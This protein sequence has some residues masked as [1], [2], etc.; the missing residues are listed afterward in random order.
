VAVPADLALGRADERRLMQVLLN[1]VGNAIKF[2][3]VGKVAIRAELI[4]DAFRVAVTDT[5]PGIAEGDRERIFEEFQQADSAVARTKGGT[6]LGLAIAR[7]IIE[8]HGGRLW[9]ESTPGVGSTFAFVVPVRVDQQV[10]AV[11]RRTAS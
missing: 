8:M 9:L 6:G 3:E 7:R 4:G 1:L 11:P 2:T 5:G 10:T